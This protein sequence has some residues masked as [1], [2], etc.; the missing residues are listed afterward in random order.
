[1]V[2]FQEKDFEDIRP[3]HDEEINPALNRIIAVPEFPKILE[4]FF[5]E[6]DKDQIITN[7]SGIKTSLDFQK[8]FMHPL[9]YSIVHKTSKGLSTGGFDKLSHGKPYLFVA[10]HRDIVLDSAILQVVLV[11]F[12]H[13]TSEITFGSNLMT[14][15]FIIDLGKVNRMFKVYRGGNR[16]ELLRNSQLLSAYIRYTLTRKNVSAWIAQRSGRTKDGSDKTEPGLLKMLN[17]SGSKDFRNSFDEL[18]IV[19]LAISYEYEPCC[20]L[21]VKETLSALKGISYQKE[22]NEDLMSIITGITQP[23]GRI[24]IEA[25]TPLNEYLHLTDALQSTNDKINKL[26]E[27]IDSQIYSHYKLWPNNYIAHDILKESRK[28]A[29]HYTPADEEQFMDY[30]QREL[31]LFKDSDNRYKE[32]FLKIYANAVLNASLKS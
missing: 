9:V 16:R 31:S 20:S 23:K 32:V 10:N 29:G 30:M 11:D 27:I 28:Y 5:P 24:H 25:C 15:Q 14:N 3:Y 22:P 7:L 8:Q 18:N 19:P 6:K 4:F 1:M 26:T 17:I 13:A 21:K 2:M 12:G